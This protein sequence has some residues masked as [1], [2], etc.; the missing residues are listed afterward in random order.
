[1]LQFV[2]VFRSFL[3][4]SFCRGGSSCSAVVEWEA[5]RILKDPK[6]FDYGRPVRGLS[7]YSI[8]IDNEIQY[9][10]IY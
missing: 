6:W 10:L 5:K 7:K 9:K 2:T 1:V 3:A 8:I 4:E